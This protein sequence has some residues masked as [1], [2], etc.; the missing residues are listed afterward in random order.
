MDSLPNSFQKQLKKL[1]IVAVYLFGS[2]ARGNTGPLSDYDVGILF[3]ERVNSSKYFDLKLQLISD[4][5]HFFRTNQVDVVILNTASS[6]LAMNVISEGKILHC[7][8]R[9]YLIAFETHTMNAYF[10]YLPHAEYFAS[11]LFKRL[12]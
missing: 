7:S 11:S 6:L 2:R 8:D 1:G 5:C 10:D 4:F 3:N 9:E 12:A